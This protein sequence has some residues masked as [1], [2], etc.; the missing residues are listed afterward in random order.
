M[1]ADITSTKVNIESRYAKSVVDEHIG[2]KGTI[3]TMS[4]VY[5]VPYMESAM[6]AYRG[7]DIGYSA[8]FRSY[9]TIILGKNP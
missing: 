7:M 9:Y 8:Q 2:E 1:C 4:F 5:L 6:E 3:C